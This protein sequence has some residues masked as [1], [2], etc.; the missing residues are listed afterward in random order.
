MIKYVNDEEGGYLVV[1][2]RSRRCPICWAD[3]HRADEPVQCRDCGLN[4]H[5]WCGAYHVDW[6]CRPCAAA[7]FGYSVS[8]LD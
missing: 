6:F 2:G 4:V 5:H 1:K 7:R 3:F 8:V